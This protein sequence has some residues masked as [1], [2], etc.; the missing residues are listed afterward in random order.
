VAT[1]RSTEIADGRAPA[2]ELVLRFG[3]WYGDS[4]LALPLP[5]R[6]RVQVHLPRT[7]PP[8]DDEAIAAAF[9]RPIGQSPI[10]ELARGRSR[11]L[12]LV[13]DLTRPTPAFRVL[14]FL[15]R[16]LAEAGIPASEVRVL[17]ATGT[18]GAPSADVL[19][20]KIGAESGACRL[21]VHDDRAQ[22]VRAGA[23]RFGTPVFV[24]PEVP[25]SDL[26]IGIG[27]VYP[28]HTAGFGGGS[29]LI[30]GALGRRSIAHLHLGHD[31]V[32]GAYDIENDFR[33]DV[34]EIAAMLGFRSLVSVH[35]DA[36]R[37]VVRV[38]TGDP[39][40]H[41]VESVRFSL[42]AYSAPGPGDADVVIANAYPMDVS[43]TF[44]RSK[45]MIPL[46]AARAG[47]SRVVIAA[48]PEGVGHH[49][50]YPFAVIPRFH[51]QEMLARRLQ[52][53]GPR[54]VATKIGRRVLRLVAGK[55]T[56]RPPVAPAAST[57]APPSLR[58]EP[59]L[60]RPPASLAPPLP[61][62]IPGMRLAASW[63]DVI[64]QIAREQGGDRDLSVAVYP[65]APL[66]CLREGAIGKEGLR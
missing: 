32:D 31:G 59:W 8:L 20:R 64:A 3:A 44:M 2:D 26:L 60:F 53:L 5:S 9:E 24:N 63:S 48:C 10:R 56:A 30:L 43:L 23:T 65:C 39:A 54:G 17:V 28:Q 1:A 13:D 62:R 51:R 49:G 57:T 6:W 18:H 41:Y 21:I 22:V 55:K 7:P 12:I 19:A 61:D 4:P 46:F 34:D 33:R 29:K 15:L 52:M 14:P 47:A 42:S 36:S 66:Q 25:R 45:G 16:Q 50:L 35:V 27:G 38:V 40:A 58:H 11:P 37:D